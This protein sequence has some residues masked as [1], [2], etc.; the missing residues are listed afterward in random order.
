LRQLYIEPLIG[1]TIKVGDA[2]E[3]SYIQK[4]GEMSCM[5][6]EANLLTCASVTFDGQYLLPLKP[7]KTGNTNIGTGEWDGLDIFWYEDFLP[8]T[9]EDTKVRRSHATMSFHWVNQSQEFRPIRDGKVISD[10]PFN[11]WR[12]AR[13]FLARKKQSSFDWVQR[14]GDV[15]LPLPMFLA[16]HKWASVTDAPPEQILTDSD[17]D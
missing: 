8:H 10:D 11:T 12:W 4:L 13:V 2:E 15:P 14:E 17:E 16:M 5:L 7:S 1:G 6:S 3:W 9:V